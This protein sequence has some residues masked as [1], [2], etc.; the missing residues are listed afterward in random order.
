MKVNDL[1]VKEI[2]TSHTPGWIQI[3]W[4]GG[5]SCGTEGEV[6]RV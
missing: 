1:K 4:I 5:R 6:E 2:E 3:Q